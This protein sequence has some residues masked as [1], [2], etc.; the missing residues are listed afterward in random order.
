MLPAL[1]VLVCRPL[2][3]LLFHTDDDSSK[4]GT[5]RPKSQRMRPSTAVGRTLVVTGFPEGVTKKQ[6]YKCCRKLGEVEQLE[7]PVEGMFTVWH[8]VSC[9]HSLSTHS[10]IHPHTST[11]THTASNTHQ[12]CRNKYWTF[13][14]QSRSV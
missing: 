3:C 9:A 8:A 4:V 2:L 14:V 7:F 11:H 1:L 13:S 10:H 5:L 12:V 6:F